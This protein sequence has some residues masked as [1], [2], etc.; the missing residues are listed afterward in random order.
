M[1]WHGMACCDVG[2]VTLMLFY[3]Y[4]SIR[5]QAATRA[6]IEAAEG[7]KCGLTKK[8]SADW[9]PLIPMKALDAGPL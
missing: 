6:Q 2:V 5:G 9:T 7:V 8:A 1:A 3:R 4:E